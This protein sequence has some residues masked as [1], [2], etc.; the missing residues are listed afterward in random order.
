MSMT[1]SRMRKHLQLGKNFDVII[2]CPKFSNVVAILV[3][4]VLVAL[5]S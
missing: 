2:W 1:K 4:A 5:V 3:V